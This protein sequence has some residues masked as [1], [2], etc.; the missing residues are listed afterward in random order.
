[1]TQVFRDNV[2]VSLTIGGDPWYVVDAE[3]E[4]SRMDTPNY[5]DLIMVPDIDETVPNLPDKIG[6]LIGQSFELFAKTDLI[7]KRD[8]NAE[9]DNLLF[10]GQLSNISATGENSYE[11]IAYDP[12]QQPFASEENGGT[13]QNDTLFLGQPEY[14]YRGSIWQLTEGTDFENKE[15]VIQS[16]RLVQECLEQV[17]ITDYE[18]ELET[19]GVEVEGRNGTYTGGYERI[20]WFSDTFIPVKEALNRA[21]ERCKAEWWFD[22]S[23]TFHFGVPRP[24][25]HEL[26]FITDADAGKTTPPY[27]SV[28]VVGSG[29][30]SKK[31]VGYRRAHMEIEDKIVVE[32]ELARNEQGDTIANFGN[33]KEPLYEYYNLEVSTDAQAKDVAS[34]LIEDLGEQQSDGVVTVVGFPEIVP[35]DG[36]IMPQNKNENEP[37]F[38]K[39]QPMGGQGYNVYKVVHRLNST[40]G[41]ITKIHCSGVTGVTRTQVSSRQANTAYDVE[42]IKNMTSG[43]GTQTLYPQ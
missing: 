29:A 35:M 1:M 25:K 32:A 30:S 16:S 43:A 4:L 18:I 42:K 10:A 28:R 23:G 20:L 39:R 41:F 7:S 36:I 24:S 14:D 34:K 27:Q 9:E 8:T 19:G 37:N 3:V 6:Q 40:D 31:D 33:T 11:G 12:A 26:K 22:K 17:N 13:I 5:V 15:Q 21:R 2:E 38:S